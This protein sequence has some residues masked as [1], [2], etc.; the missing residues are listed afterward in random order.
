SPPSAVIS[1]RPRMHGA[2]FAARSSTTPTRSRAIWPAAPTG[3]AT[4]P[5]SAFYPST[6]SPSPRCCPITSERRYLDAAAHAWRF[7]RSAIKYDADKVAR[8]LASGTD[9]RGDGTVLGILPL[10]VITFAALLPYHLRA[11]LSRR[12]RACMAL[13]SQRDQVRRR[14]GRALSGQRHRPARRR[15]RARHSTP[16]RHHLRRAAALSPPSAVISTRP[17]MHGASFAARSSTTPTR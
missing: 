15:D 7:V 3:A 1:T 2:S 13:R 10:D 11:P 5:C 4:G 12:G 17:R 9:R 8:Y 6:S 14:Q 16:R